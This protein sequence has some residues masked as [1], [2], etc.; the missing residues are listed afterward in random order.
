MASVNR[1]SEINKNLKANRQ[2]LLKEINEKRE[3]NC[4]VERSNRVS[5]LRVQKRHFQGAYESCTQ[6][7]TKE[8]VPDSGRSSWVKLSLLVHTEKKHFP[9]KNNAIFG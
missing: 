3:S 5:L 1:P 2:Q 7:Q 4:L 9:T 8:P 6:T